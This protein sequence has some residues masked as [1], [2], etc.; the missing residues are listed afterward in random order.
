MR[1]SALRLPLVKIASSRA[2]VCR[3]SSFDVLAAAMG[4]SLDGLAQ[5][6]RGQ[7]EIRA[8]LHTILQG[9]GRLP[10]SGSGTTAVTASP[11][12]SM[13]DVP[14]VF[15]SHRAADHNGAQALAS[16]LRTQ[17]GVEVWYDGWEIVGATTSPPR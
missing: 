6:D 15:L 1:S 11:A 17:F 9:Q 2:P 14:R 3:L 10:L 8:L 16:A 13:D 12:V 4:E 5:L 7:A